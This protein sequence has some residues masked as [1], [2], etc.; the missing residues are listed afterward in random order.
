MTPENNQSMGL[1]IGNGDQDNYVKLVTTA[2][3]GAGGIEFAREELIGEEV[4]FAKQRADEAMPG[5]DV[6][7]LF[8]KVDPLTH[9]VEPSYQVF[10]NGKAAPRETLGDPVPIPAAWLDGPGALA[11]GIISTSAGPGPVFPATWERIDVEPE[12]Q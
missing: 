11:V 5:P 7:E 6:V 8:L 12:P 9:T 4:T 1:F 3:G 2:N 10:I